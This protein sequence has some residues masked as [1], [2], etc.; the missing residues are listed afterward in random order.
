MGQNTVTVAQLIRPVAEG[1]APWEQLFTDN[2]A[3][4]MAA[5]GAGERVHHRPQ[6]NEEAS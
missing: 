1:K 6:F 2:C 4:L 5:H 3:F